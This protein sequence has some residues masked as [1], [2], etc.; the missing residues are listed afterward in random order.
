MFTRTL[1][2][3][4]SCSLDDSWFLSSI[5]PPLDSCVPC[6]HSIQHVFLSTNSLSCCRPCH[7][8]TEPTSTGSLQ[9]LLPVHLLL[10]IVSKPHTPA[11]ILVCL[12]LTSFISFS[13]S[14]WICLPHELPVG[15]G[16]FHLTYPVSIYFYTTVPVSVLSVS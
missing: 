5:Q 8:S 12:S 16:A 1:L 11:H 3:I 4:I 14:F 15:P 13:C 7:S 2:V 6:F 10:I 9:S